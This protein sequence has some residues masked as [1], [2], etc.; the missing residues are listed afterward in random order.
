MRRFAVGLLSCISGLLLAVAIMFA[1][2]ALEEL[3]VGNYEYGAP[4]TLH[5][6]NAGVVLLAWLALRARLARNRVASLVAACTAVSSIV[7]AIIALASNPQETKSAALRAAMKND[8]RLLVAAQQQF[9]RD[10]GR[11]AASAP[12]GYRPSAG[13]QIL[14][15]ERTPDGWNASVTHQMLREVCVVYVGG[16]PFP[17]AVADGEPACSSESSGITDPEFL[18][19]IAALVGLAAMFAGTARWLD[20]RESLDPSL[21]R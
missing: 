3:V 9:R 4:A 2:P 20:G 6:I 11:Y 13:V 15:V 5:L 14:A 21:R 1:L 16:T 17:P 10:S 12:P 19:W 8:L 7:F 18:I